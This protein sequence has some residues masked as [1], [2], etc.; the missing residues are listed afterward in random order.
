MTSATTASGSVIRKTDPHSNSVSSA[1]ATSGPSAAIAPPSADH[2]AID[3][4]RAGPD[5]SAVI[6]ASVV[7]YAMPAASPPPTRATNSTLVRRREGGEQATS[8][9]R[10][11]CRG[12]ASSCGRAG[13]RARRGRAPS[14]AS[15]SEYPTAIRFSITCEESNAS[16]IDGRATFATDRFRLATAAT[17]ISVMRTTPRA[18]GSVRSSPGL[19]SCQCRRERSS[20]GADHRTVSNRGRPERPPPCRADVRYRVPWPSRPR[21]RRR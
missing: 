17:R 8:G 7:G 3:F 6:S 13:R 9:S 12:R 16:P 20:R 2:S 15:P 4:V 10:G 11:P 1:P 5:H 19:S 18:T 21:T 14:A